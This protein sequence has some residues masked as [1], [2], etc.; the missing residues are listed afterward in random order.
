MEWP[1]TKSSDDFTK[2][3]IERDSQVNLSKMSNWT[4]ICE[5]MLD[6]EFSHMYY[7]KCYEELLKRG[8]TKEEIFE[9]RKFA[10]MTAGWLNFE[11]ILWDWVNLDEKDIRHAI[12][13]LYDE[14]A[15]GA[16]SP[17]LCRR[18]KTCISK[19]KKKI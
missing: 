18:N 11:M 3:V 5:E 19:T 12:K 9:M 13:L 10:W 17:T 1:P 14:R 7:T 15:I 2:E 8:K 4:L 6:T 16:E